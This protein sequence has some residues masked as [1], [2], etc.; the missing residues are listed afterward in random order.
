MHSHILKHHL[1]MLFTVNKKSQG[2]C[3]TYNIAYVFTN[4]FLSFDFVFF[5][6]LNLI[7][8]NSEI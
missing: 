2:C 1:R 3:D 6:I 8:S 4:K 5:H 7:T